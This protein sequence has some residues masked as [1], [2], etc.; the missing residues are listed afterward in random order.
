MSDRVLQQL[1]GPEAIRVGGIEADARGLEMRPRDVVRFAGH[2][3]FT[4]VAGK[5]PRRSR[6]LLGND[7]NDG[8]A[9]TFNP[10]RHGGGY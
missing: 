5:P 4:S 6:H 9:G 7:A 8:V 3:W 10:H 1:R 2:G